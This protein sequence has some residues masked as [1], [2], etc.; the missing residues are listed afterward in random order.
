MNFYSF[1]E[2]KS[3]ANCIRFVEDVFGERISDGRCRAVW[4]NGTNPQ[5]VSVSEK[6]WYD[7]SEEVGGGILELCAKTKFGG[8][9]QQ[10]Q[11]WLG[12]WLGLEPKRLLS[13]KPMHNLLSKRL[14]EGYTETN[15]YYY[16]DELGNARLV[17][18]R[19]EHPELGKTFIQEAPSGV[20][21]R[22][23]EHFLYNLPMIKASPWAVVVE[24][25]KDSET[26]IAMKIPATTNV[27]G[28][29][30]WDDSYSK[31]LEGKDVV[32]CRDND[33]AGLAHARVVAASVVGKAKTVRVICPSALYKGDVT[34]WMKKES[35]TKFDLLT[36]IKASP[37]I[38]VGD[39]FLDDEETKI[40]KAKVANETALSNTHVVTKIIDGKEK[41]VDE[42]F[43]MHQLAAKIHERF[44]GFP[45]RLGDSRMFD[46]DRD[47]GRVEFIDNKS[48]LFAWIAMKSKHVIHWGRVS[49]AV[50]KDELYEGLI[51]T[52]T[53]Y[54]SISQVPD[55][56]RRTDVYY[57]Y[58][59]KVAPSKNNE[60]FY[61]LMDFFHTANTSSK[62]LLRA[63]FAAP[64]Y[65]R[66]GVRRP[67][68]II[69]SESGPGV[70]KSTIAELLGTLYRCAPIK[71][72]KQELQFD[73]KELLKRVVS[74][75]GRSSR[76][77]LVDNVTGMF[78]NPNFAA[79]VT[80]FGISGK[81]PYGRGEETRPNNLTYIITANSANINN[82][83]ASRS[84]GIML[85]KPTY[86]ANWTRDVMAYIEKNRYTIFGDI[87]DII[88]RSRP[89]I[90]PNT[91]IPEFE[92][93][94][95]W[96]MCI[97][98][99]EYDQAI[100]G[101]TTQR[102][103]ANVEEEL[104]RQCGEIIAL[105]LRELLVTKFAEDTV[106]FIRYEIV[107]MWL[108][109]LRPHTK[110][111]DVRNFAKIGLIKEINKDIRRYPNSGTGPL[112]A[113]RSTGLMWI[114]NKV[115]QPQY[116]GVN[117][118]GRGG[119]GNKAES[120]KI[121]YDEKI[122][123]LLPECIDIEAEE[124]TITPFNSNTSIADLTTTQEEDD[125]FLPP[126]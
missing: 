112:S 52:A 22:D 26:L 33:D 4:R 34:D 82:D 71:T 79:M 115:I 116:E 66:F 44:L 104:A 69:D 98:R 86:N 122:K 59:D 117:I 2:I 20:R 1:D 38:L 90:T 9:I 100:Q 5:S 118:I 16:T 78:D 58:R 123:E 110:M 95:L 7:F 85:A 3:R 68:W 48:A 14:E 35:G 45:R 114:G 105:K 67:C 60:C 29:K 88:S 55:Y 97:D 121:I 32:I 18:I 91:R 39:P 103:D 23:V 109:D 119:H 21:P 27:G 81:A 42:P 107:D 51:Q 28:S 65:Y 99:S 108:S 75:E 19:V 124:I 53:R 126:F 61:G 64:I 49:G 46:H 40:C 72:N 50:T 102:E 24:G 80:D 89:S 106:A 56:P 77:L 63:L 11:N 15:R 30:K 54:E 8:D 13:K 125:S 70:G 47:S 6:E 57:A 96:P 74:S 25:E 87:I 113:L 41:R 120:I 76:I 92:Q 62:I 111:Q 37:Q 17:V 83:I 12:D 93:E 84:F 10:A 43:A 94:I 73:F 101:I 31:Y 36:L